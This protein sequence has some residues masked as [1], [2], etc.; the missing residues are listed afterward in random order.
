[1]KDWD[2]NAEISGNVGYD[3]SSW[4][5]LPKVSVY[6]RWKAMSELDFRASVDEA[7]SLNLQ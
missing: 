7:G 3:G 1:M 5:W 2:L 6:V 4:R